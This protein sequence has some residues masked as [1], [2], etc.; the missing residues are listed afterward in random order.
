MALAH[1]GTPSKKNKR[2]DEVHPSGSF[3]HPLLRRNAPEARNKLLAASTFLSPSSAAHQSYTKTRHQSRRP[4]TTEPLQQEP[5]PPTSHLDDSCCSSAEGV[6]HSTTNW[7]F[8]DQKGHDSY[9]RP[10]DWT[11]M[12]LYGPADG[13]S[14]GCFA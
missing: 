4:P 9:I 5:R 14:A 13:Q 12:A 2:L 6:H 10:G 7:C 1:F 11:P 8:S 3:S